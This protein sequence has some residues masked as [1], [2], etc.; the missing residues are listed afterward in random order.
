MNEYFVEVRVN[1][2]KISVGA[3]FG[4]E[5]WNFLE[6]DLIEAPTAKK[7]IAEML[8]KTQMRH[9]DSTIVLTQINKV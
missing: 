8:L 1:G 3:M 4:M 6:S 7:A 2:C 5:S 9:Q